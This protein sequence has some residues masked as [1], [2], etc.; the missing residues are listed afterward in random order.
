M[1]EVWWEEAARQDLLSLPSIDDAAA[2]DSAV[3]YFART[4]VGFVRHVEDE[5]RP[6]IANTRL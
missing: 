4:G 5:I 3:Q 1:R 2:V 6:Y